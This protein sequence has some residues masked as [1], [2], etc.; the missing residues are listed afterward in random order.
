V[1]REAEPEP[2]VDKF[3]TG[4]VGEAC[5][6]GLP[7]VCSEGKTSCFEFALTCSPN[8]A[9]KPE[10]CDGLDNNCDGTVDENVIEPVSGDLRITLDGSTSDYVYASWNGKELG[11]AWEDRRDGNP[12][13]YFTTVD[14]RG[15]RTLA[16]DIRVSNT[17]DYSSHPALVWDGAA[18]NIVYADD[19][20]SNRELYLQRVSPHGALMG[21]AVRLT[22][23]TGNS[24]W[25]DVVW[26]G[27]ELAVAWQDGR[28]GSSNDNIYFA[29]FSPSGS[30]IGKEGVVT[31]ASGHQRSPI[32]KF[33]GTTFGLLWSDNR[34]GTQVYFRGLDRDGGFTTGEKALTRSPGK[35]AWADLAW[36]GADWATV[37]T[38]NRFGDDEVYFARFD[39][40][41]NLVGEEVRVTEAEGDSGY[42]SIDWNGTQFGISWQ[43]EREGNANIYFTLLNAQGVKTGSDEKISTG[44]GKSQFTTGVWTG[45]VYSFCF[46]DTRDG[47]TGN[48]EIY[49]ASMGCL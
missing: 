49:F 19:S 17:A 11:I 2:L 45:D 7:G 38:D 48:S 27:S 32:L 35:A 42:P 47:P 22:Q 21:S 12:E 29:R 23:A 13:I 43:D 33:N 8:M 15:K 5:D 18:W 25:P 37:W 44:S 3:C 46:K 16:Y 40:Q 30:R 41:G 24:D 1:V 4:V 14:A 26:T 9:G 20:E 6:T 34:D 28:A 39:L 36:S 31:S 10:V